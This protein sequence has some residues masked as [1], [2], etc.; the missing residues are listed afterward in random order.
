MPL[1]NQAAAAKLFEVVKSGLAHANDYDHPW[2]LPVLITSNEGRIVVL[3]DID[4]QSGVW[5]FFTDRRSKKVEQLM[6]LKGEASATFYDP[7]QQIQLRLFGR[8]TEADVKQRITYWSS[9]KISQQLSYATTDA[10]GSEM[11]GPGNGLSQRW[12]LGTPSEEELK[13]A[14]KHFAAF[15]FS[16][17]EIEMLSLSRSQARRCKWSSWNGDDFKWLVP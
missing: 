5:T 9:L 8:V 14:F 4:M 12:T 17:D 16:I 10:P 15:N 6:L 11:D 1:A 2:R 7:A 13:V 3:R